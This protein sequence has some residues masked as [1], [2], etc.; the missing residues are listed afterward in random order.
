M[1]FIIIRAPQ[2]IP[3]IQPNT[4]INSCKRPIITSAKFPSARPMI[5]TPKPN[6]IQFTKPKNAPSNPS[7]GT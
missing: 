6:M 1:H 5:I 3:Q 2:T 7:P 4:G